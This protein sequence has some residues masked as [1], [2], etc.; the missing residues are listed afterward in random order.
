MKTKKNPK[1]YAFALLIGALFAFCMAG[2]SDSENQVPFEGNE[3]TQDESKQFCSES[4]SVIPL[5]DAMSSLEQ[6]LS[7]VEG[8]F[9]ATRA[10]STRKIESV[11]VHYSDLYAT[12][13]GESLP[14][15]YI[16]NFEDDEGF[17]VLGAN[18]AVASIVAVTEKGHIDPVT[19]SVQEG[20][21]DNPDMSNFNWYCE[22]DDDYYTMG[23]NTGIVTESIKNAIIKLDD[24]NQTIPEGGGDSGNGGNGGNGGSGNGGNGNGSNQYMTCSPLVMINWSQGSWGTPN[25]YNKYCYKTTLGGGI[26]YVHAGCSTIALSMIVATNE[27]PTNLYVHGTLLDYAAMRTYSNATWLPAE[28]QE[29]VSLLIGAIF[30]NVSKTFEL[31]AGTCITP[32]AIKNLMPSMGYTNVAMLSG[33]NFDSSMLSRVSSMLQGRKPVFVS[34]IEGLLGGHSWVIDG[35]TYMSGEYKLHCNWGWGGIDNGYFDS[36]CFNPSSVGNDFSWHFRVI[37]YD[38]PSGTMTCTMS[39]LP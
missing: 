13:S 1:S 19:L 11:D 28:D 21:E 18:T 30:N 36:S 12:R 7:E 32:T 37:S 24:G 35:A 22:E 6:F 3:E 25:V 38:I 33:S 17:A 2:C 27:F 23:P 39:C 20:Q 16:V 4:I 14:D 31:D 29:Y 26:Q 10:G 9:C 34:A 8:D 5:E 15:A